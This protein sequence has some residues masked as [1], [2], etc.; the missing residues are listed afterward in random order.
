MI[1]ICFIQALST[2]NAAIKKR[3]EQ[4]IGNPHIAAYL[5]DPRYLDNDDVID[6]NQQDKAREWLNKINDG[7]DVEF[8]KFKIRQA[9]EL[10]SGAGHMF[11]KK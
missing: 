3:Y 8:D 2:Y 7:F 10:Y 6:L 11:E 9:D 4:A 1:L 5:T